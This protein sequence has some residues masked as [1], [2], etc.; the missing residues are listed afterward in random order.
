MSGGDVA[1]P[2]SNDVQRTTTRNSNE[3]GFPCEIPSR[4]R[5]IPRGADFLTTT[6]G[7]AVTGTALERAIAARSY[8]GEDN[9]IPIALVGCGGRGSG[10]ATQALS[11]TG[12]T[13]WSPWPTSSKTAS[14]A[15]S[16]IS[17]T[18]LGPDRRTRPSAS[19]WAWTRYK[20]AID[21]VDKGDVVLL[22]TPPAFRPIHFEYAVTRA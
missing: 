11:T 6:A 12:P 7:A 4:P 9:T 14:R 19:S 21:S 18:A 10:A 17:R 22:A 16:A 2:G 5:P 20:K 8:A 13:R 15:A 1:R 3:G